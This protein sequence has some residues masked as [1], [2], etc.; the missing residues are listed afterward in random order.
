V[1]KCLTEVCLLQ[2]P[3]AGAAI[4]QSALQAL[5]RL[6]FLALRNRIAIANVM[7]QDIV[8]TGMS[9]D[10]VDGSARVGPCQPCGSVGLA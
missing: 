7:S 4:G 10:F 3:I 9:Q 2:L 6:G 1:S 5:G 8:D